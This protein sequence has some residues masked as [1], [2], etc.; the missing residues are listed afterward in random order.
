[1]IRERSR[2]IPLAVALVL[3]LAGPTATAA[4]LAREDVPELLRPWVDW[5]LRGHEAEACPFLQASGERHCVWPSR[6]E[7]DLDASGGRFEQGLFVAAESDVFLPGGAGEPAAWPE[8]VRVDGALAPVLDLGGRPGLRLPRGAHRVSGRLVWSSLPPVVAIPPETGLV[9]LCLDGKAVPFPRR[10][11]QGRL[12]LRE[13]EASARAPGAEESHL[14]VDVH[15]RVVDEIPLRLETV[16]TLRVAGQ[17]RDELLGRALPDGFVPLRLEGPLPARLDPGGRLRVQV[18]PGRFSLF[19]DARHEGPADALGLPAQP[20]A[21]GPPATWDASEVW[22]VET[23]PALRLVEV[24]GVPPVDPTQTELPEEWRHLPAYRLEPGDVL[25]LVEKRRGTAGGAADQLSL[26]RAWHLDFD[27]GGASVSDRIEGTLREATRLEMGAR[28]TLGRAAVNG[29]DQPITR[30]RAEDLLGLE[31]PLGPVRI[32]S[33][34]RVGEGARRLPAVGWAHDFDAVAGTLELPPGW[35]LLHAGGVDAAEPTWIG[36]WT[37]LD[38]F[39]VMVVAMATLRL[40]GRAA[41]ALAFVTLALSYTEPGAP[42][43]VWVAVLAGEALRRVVSTGRLA[44]AVRLFHA[45]SLLALVVFAVPFAVA[46]IRNGLFPALERPGVAAA[47]RAEAR[48]PE[49]EA[50]P[51]ELREQLELDAAQRGEPGRAEAP[52]EGAVAPVAPSPGKVRRLADGSRLERESLRPGARALRFAPDP[53]ASIPTGPGRPEWQWQRVELAWSGPVRQDQ[54][55]SLWLVPPWANG[56]LALL[57]TG[58]LAALAA[59]MLGDLRGRFTTP[60][61]GASR[62]AALAAALLVLPSAARAEFPSPELLNELRTRL[63]EDPECH[64]SCA[65]LARLA[66]GV[67]PDRLGLRLAVEV[68]AQTAIPLPGGAGG[69]DEAGFVPE[70]VAIDGR[71]AEALRRD[72]AGRLWVGLAPGSHT[73]V[74]SGALPPRATLELPLPLRPHRV[75]IVG[76]PRGWTVVGLDPDG[77]A[78]TALQL[79]RDSASQREAGADARRLE[80]TPI[81]PFVRVERSLELGL[82]WQVH[83]QVLRVAPAEG[84]IVLEVPL[85][86]GESVTTPGVQVRDRHALVTLQPGAFAAGWSSVLAGADR[87]A[88]E[89]PRDVAWTE[90]WRLDAGALWHVEAQGIP[91]VDLPSEGRRF[92]EWQPWPG[93]GVTLAVERPAGAGGATLTVDRSELGLRPGLRATDATLALALRSSQGGQHGVTL[94]EGAELTE[95]RMDGVGQPL[96]QE[97]RRVPFAFAPGRHEVALAWREPRGVSALVHGSEVDLGLE[98]V[99]AHLSIELPESRWIL[100]AGGPRLGPVVLFWPVLAVVAGLA[101][102]LGR[103]AWTPLRGRHW[104]LLGVGLTQAPLPAAAVVV[105]W[106]LALGWRGR[107]AERAAAGSAAAFNLVQLSLAILTLAA[108]AALVF[109][110]QT[111]L[112]GAPQMQIAGNGS[113]FRMLRWYQ[114]RAEAL[115]P[116][117]WVFSLSLW[118]YRFAM[119]AWSLWLAQSLVSWLRW[120]F[121]QWSAGGIW[122]S[123]RGRRALASGS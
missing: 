106:L 63:L 114:D 80:P 112:L 41:G 89:A 15:R 64:P 108:L 49:A 12:W 8:E 116:R 122:R 31:V 6:L 17:A 110:I 82:T 76:T 99:N 1:M 55:L 39:V 11:A 24:E 69:D 42:R 115:L 4:P 10:D 105:A 97:G 35:R 44:S 23:R 20:G 3:F 28:T 121:Q 14:E 58:L 111:G 120:G 95:L 57:R 88:L 32:E 37:L 117:P 83:T 67:K 34:S 96:R 53:E 36:R 94:P 86:A 90:V 56:A 102:A 59:S 60:P 52:R 16:V 113:S 50:P 54:E 29:A 45:A 21:E 107:Q 91:P 43:L 74:L 101:F 25:R 100:F 62:A 98:S 92:R 2:R 71:A 79:V 85:L 87:L 70:R 46:Q 84:A 75:E 123:L 65:T 61:G 13:P 77:R 109:A 30:R 93:E 119:L 73:L 18:R 51:G 103:M 9:T 68:A 47:A 38:L 7:L 40:Y 27:G 78:G 22:A 5:V 118:F 33:D 72:A 26:Q 81:P 66:L 19:L 104:L 48:A